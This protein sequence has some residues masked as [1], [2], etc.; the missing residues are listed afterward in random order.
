MAKTRELEQEYLECM[1]RKVKKNMNMKQI[2]RRA[3]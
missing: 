1:T 2:Q 3:S